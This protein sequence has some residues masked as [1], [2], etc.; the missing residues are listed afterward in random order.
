MLLQSQKIVRTPLSQP[1]VFKECTGI[2]LMLNRIDLVEPVIPVPL[3]HFAASWYLFCSKQLLCTNEE[4]CVL[5]TPRWSKPM[6][7]SKTEKT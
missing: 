4:N 5:E 7:K 2:A 6:K 3:L 1:T